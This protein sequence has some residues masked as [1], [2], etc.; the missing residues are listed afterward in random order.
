MSSLIQAVR[1]RPSRTLRH[2]WPKGFFGWWAYFADHYLHG[3]DRPVDWNELRAVEECGSA[4]VL[5]ANGGVAAFCGID[6]D[7]IRRIVRGDEDEA[8]ARE[9]DVKADAVAEV[10]ARLRSDLGVSTS[11]ELTRLRISEPAVP[12]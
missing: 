11:S 10:R 5:F 4:L 6:V 2:L 8:I 9:L 3:F 1:R 12:A 7:I